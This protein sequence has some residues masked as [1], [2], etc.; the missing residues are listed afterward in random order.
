MLTIQSLDEFVKSMVVIQESGLEN[1]VGAYSYDCFWRCVSYLKTGSILER[2]AELYAINYFS[3]YCGLST[4]SYLISAGMDYQSAREYVKS[5]QLPMSNTKGI[6][7]LNVDSISWYQNNG[8]SSIGGASHAVIINKIPN[9]DGSYNVYDP[10]NGRSFTISS[11]EANVSN[12][13]YPTWI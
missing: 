13:T 1:I 8:Y 5:N 2:D 11:S 4:D 7:Y 9:N 3:Y 12:G 6:V 10:Q